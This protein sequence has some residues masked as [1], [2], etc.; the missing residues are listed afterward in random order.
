MY[1]SIKDAA[2][3]KSKAFTMTEM[4]AILKQNQLLSDGTT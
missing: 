3:A 4:Q 2:A 1:K